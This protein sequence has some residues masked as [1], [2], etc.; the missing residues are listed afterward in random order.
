MRNPLILMINLQ[1]QIFS[2]VSNSV[3]R[4]AFSASAP[5]MFTKLSTAALENL[6]IVPG[7]WIKPRANTAATGFFTCLHGMQ[8]WLHNF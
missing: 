8:S 7:Q 4:Q 2:S 1:C 5:R 6:D 3:L